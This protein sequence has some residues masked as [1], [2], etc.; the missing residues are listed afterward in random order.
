MAEELDKKQQQQE[1]QAQKDAGDKKPSSGRLVFWIAISAVIIL[2]AVVAVVLV[3][4]T[5][6]KPP[7]PVDLSQEA[8]STRI[9]REE[10]EQMAFSDPPIEAIVNLKG[11]EGMRFL[12]VVLV[13]AYDAK[14]YKDL[15]A[16][17]TE[18]L[19]ELQNLVID[20]LS[21][22]SLEDI[23]RPNARDEIRAEL[24]RLVNRQL[25][26]S[27]KSMFFFKKDIGH[28]ADIYINEFIIQ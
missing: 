18:R 1:D 27:K 8:D 20:R 16:I 5:M 2:N 25:P 12:K 19:P 28:V 22:R 23:Q 17:L 15:G 10:M 7:K 24:K 4:F 6:P 14:K 11:S 9:V 13:F 26:K 3:Q 21:S